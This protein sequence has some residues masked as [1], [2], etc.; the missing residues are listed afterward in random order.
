[1]RSCDFNIQPGGGDFRRREKSNPAAL[2]LMAFFVLS[3]FMSILAFF[4]ALIAICR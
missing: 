1:M 2:L 4:T 3:L